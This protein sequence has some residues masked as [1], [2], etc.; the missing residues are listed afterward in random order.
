MIKSLIDAASHLE[1]RK[2]AERQDLGK[3]KMSAE[4]R[5][6]FEEL[7]TQVKAL[8]SDVLELAEPNSVSYHGP[9]FFLE[10]LPRRKK[11]T[12]LLAL[13]F[14]E[15]DDPSGFAKD[16]TEKKFFVHARHEGGVSLSVWNAS[17][18]ESALPLIRQ[19]HAASNE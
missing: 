19:A 8:D 10:V 2:L 11:L 15:V 17:D 18:V 4:A 3:V 7:R 5:A 13:D 16:A 9:A 6:L 1:K 12:L 14:N